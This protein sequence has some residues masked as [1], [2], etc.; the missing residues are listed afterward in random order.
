MWSIWKDH[1]M[2]SIFVF[3]VLKFLWWITR[4]PSIKK[5]F[6]SCIFLSWLPS[7]SGKWWSERAW[8]RLCA[9]SSLK[10]QS[11][12]EVAQNQWHVLWSNPQL[13][14]YDVNLI[15]FIIFVCRKPLPADQSK[16]NY[17]ARTFLICYPGLSFCR[18]NWFYRAVCCWG[19]G[20]LSVDSWILGGLEEQRRW[21]A[22]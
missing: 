17:S 7:F 1:P 2:A 16:K 19:L 15:Y 12:P 6:I 18:S 8:S 10:L 13:S 21:S 9:S 4:L 14:W 20:L 11:C 5:F 22:R 3:Y